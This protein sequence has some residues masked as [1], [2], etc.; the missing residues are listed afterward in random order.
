MHPFSSTWGSLCAPATSR[1]AQIPRI[2]FSELPFVQ[3]LSV[4]RAEKEL[5]GHGQAPAASYSAV[6][7]EPRGNAEQ[8]SVSCPSCS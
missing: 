7:A 8:R 3:C 4:C 1:D 5:P 2:A 6:R